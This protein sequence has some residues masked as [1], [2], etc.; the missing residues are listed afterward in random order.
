M[1]SVEVLDFPLKTTSFEWNLGRC[2]QAHIYSFLPPIVQQTQ[3]NANIKIQKK[4][5]QFKSF[6][7]KNRDESFD[8][9]LH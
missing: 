9:S 6:E 8:L 2:Q 1:N 4:I 5:Q 7:S 3:Y